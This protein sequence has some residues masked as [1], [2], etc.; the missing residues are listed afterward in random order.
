LDEFTLPVV[1]KPVDSSGSKGVSVLKNKNDLLFVFNKAL[2]F[3]RAKRVIIEEFVASNGYQIAGDGFVV[4]GELV[5]RLF[6]N[7]HYDD[8]INPLLPMVVGN[9]VPYARSTAQQAKV[10]AELQRLITLLSI[11]HGA[12]NFDIRYTNDGEVFLM[13]IGPRNGGGGQEWRIRNSTGIEIIKYTINSALGYD[14]SDLKMES[15][16][17]YYA[18]YLLHSRENGTLEKIDFSPEIAPHIMVNDIWIKPGDKI[19]KYDG[20]DKIY[21]MIYF[22]FDSQDQM[23]YHMD[24][25]FDHIVLHMQ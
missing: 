19:M 18:T 16:V 5:F 3:S 9:S 15:P 2:S 23:E 10:H 7:E 14:C 22:T 24:N 4:N 21:G 1:V 13:D 20:S 17:G 12:M 11:Q 8:L 25:M 6:E